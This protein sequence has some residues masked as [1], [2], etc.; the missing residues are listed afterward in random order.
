MK[1]QGLHTGHISCA[2]LH[3]LVSLREDLTDCKVHFCL[4]RTPADFITVADLKLCGKLS[5]RIAHLR[6]PPTARQVM[7][8]SPE[9]IAAMG[10]CEWTHHGRSPNALLTAHLHRREL[11]SPCSPRRP[12]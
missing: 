8:R 11:E 6:R 10:L 9:A 4:S 2:A 12:Q 3:W 5:V 1:F 7:Y